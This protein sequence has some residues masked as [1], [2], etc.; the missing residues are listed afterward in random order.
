[1]E[2]ENKSKNVMREEKEGYE[3]QTIKTKI[4]NYFYFI[5]K[6]KK[7]INLPSSCIFI[8]LEMIQLLSFAFDDPHKKTWKIPDNIMENI[9]TIVGALRIAPLMRW[10]S[11]NIYIIIFIILVVL[12]FLLCLLMTMQVLFANPSS[13]IYR[14]GVSFVRHFITPLTILLT[15]PIMEVVL[16]PLKCVDGKVDTILDG[17]DCWVNIHFL[18]VIL[19]VLVNILFM[20]IVFIMITFYF[21]PFQIRNS[22]TKI[23]GTRDS[24]LFIIKI[25]FILQHLL[26]NSQYI[27]IVITLLL[28]LFNF[29]SQY[30]ENTYN[31]YILQIF[32]NLRNSAVFWTYLVL[33]FA[34]L[35]YNTSI[36]GC[37]YLLLFGYPIIMFLSFI[38]Y[39]KI[40]GD[41]N[42]TAANFNNIKDF[43]E[44]TKYITALIESYIDN[45]KELRYGRDTG[46]R[47]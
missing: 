17:G 15:I 19:G 7:E 27:S 31:N 22:T 14:I 8:I 1:M 28:S 9:S 13:K 5:L 37:V 35:F 36:N 4:Y 40:E 33:F 25:I 10:V 26:I 16:M 11:Y 34:K 18:Y 46:N 12:M 20:F 30:S 42:Y 3:T 47:K 2:A 43:M 32:V 21:S 45:G 6:D 38:I 24:F 23:S 29:V 44:R 41:F 39:Q